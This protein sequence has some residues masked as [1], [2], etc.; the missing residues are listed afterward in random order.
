MLICEN[1]EERRKHK[2]S[3]AREYTFTGFGPNSVKIGQIID[4]SRGGMAFQ[5]T[6]PRTKF[7][8]FAE[9]SLIVDDE[10]LNINQVP[11]K[12]PSKMVSVSD[13][14]IRNP[15]NFIKVRRYSVEFQNLSEL[16]LFWL[17]Y[18]LKNHTICE[19]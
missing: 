6:D 2:R 10:A 15:F 9:L 3:K 7:F 17:D 5:N 14:S 1:I 11:F 13:L 12:F 4:I 19:V 16:Q 18:F 8:Q